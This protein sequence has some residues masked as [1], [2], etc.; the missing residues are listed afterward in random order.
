MSTTPIKCFE[1]A[2]RGSAAS[3]HD[4]VDGEALSY[5][6]MMRPGRDSMLNSK[7]AAF[8]EAG[9]T[10]ALL[11]WSEGP[12]VL[13]P[14]GVPVH[15]TSKGE[16]EEPPQRNHNLSVCTTCQQTCHPAAAVRVGQ[17]GQHPPFRLY[18]Y[19]YGIIL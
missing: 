5:T 3:V 10:A 15:A 18:M 17:R 9:G 7:N 19:R 6:W 13:D 1:W 14:L 4:A 2:D 16:S 8:G 12:F 11:E